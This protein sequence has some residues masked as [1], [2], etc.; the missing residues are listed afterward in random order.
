MHQNFSVQRKGDVAH[1]HESSLTKSENF[2]SIQYVNGTGVRTLMGHMD[3]APF[4]FL[5]LAHP[6][7]ERNTT[8]F[9]QSVVFVQKNAL[10]RPPPFPRGLPLFRILHRLVVNGVCRSTRF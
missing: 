5:A 7:L 2:Q 4:P 9:R 10:F 6:L 3:R 8:F 1:L